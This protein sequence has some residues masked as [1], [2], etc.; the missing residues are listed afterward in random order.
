[1]KVKK[2]VD[3]QEDDL[4]HRLVDEIDSFNNLFSEFSKLGSLKRMS[5]AVLRPGGWWPA[6]FDFGI[7]HAKKLNFVLTTNDGC[8][9]CFWSSK[10]K[11]L[12]EFKPSPNR[13]YLLNTALKHTAINWGNLDRVHLLLT[14][15]ELY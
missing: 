10:E 3:A 2:V 11:I 12:K 9:T 6:H 13:L 8:V 14:Y 7:Y 4:S 5:F 1:M 15:K